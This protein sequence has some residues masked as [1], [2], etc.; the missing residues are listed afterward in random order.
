MSK[1]LLIAASG[2][3]VAVLTAIFGLLTNRQK[4]REDLQ[5]KYDANI[6]QQ[7]TAVY[8]PLWKQL[9]LLARFAP[10][11]PVTTRRLNDLSTTLRE[12]FFNTGGLFLSD[13]SRHAYLELQMSIV[14]FVSKHGISDQELDERLLETIQEKTTVLRAHLSKDI[15][16]R[17]L[18][19]IRV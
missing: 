13:D 7:R 5:A 18:V 12:W 2:V 16:S 17:K 14:R 15:G 4:F 19:S 1:D 9:E 6:H 10:P 3:V 11:E 8:L